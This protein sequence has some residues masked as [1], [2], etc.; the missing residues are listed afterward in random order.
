MCIRDSNPHPQRGIKKR[1]G[2]QVRGGAH[3]RAT[4]Q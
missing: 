3:R 4:A 2:D 1:E